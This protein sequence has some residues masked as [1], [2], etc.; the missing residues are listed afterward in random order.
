MKQPLSPTTGCYDDDDDNDDDDDDACAML[1]K[2]YQLPEI[3][4]LL[5]NGQIAAKLREVNGRRFSM[6]F[7]KL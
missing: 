2:T 6:N 4:N 3:F 7:H 1:G 5:F